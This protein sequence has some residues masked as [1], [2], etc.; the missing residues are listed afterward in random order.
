M[1]FQ[2]PGKGF[3]ERRAKFLAEAKKKVKAAVSSRDNLLIQTVCAVDEINKSSN[4]LFE[5]LCEWYGMHFP[6][7]K[8]SDNS[9][10]VEFV[11]G[12]DR[13]NPDMKELEK[14]FGQA[15]QQLYDKAKS[16][17]G[18]SFSEEDIRQVRALA[19]QVKML[20]TLRKNI[21]DYEI[22]LA[23]EICPNLSYLAG[24]TLAAKLVS[25]AGGLKRL[26]TMPSS[27]IQV[28]GAEKALFKHL[29]SGSRP[30]K[31]GLIFQHPLIS[32]SPKSVRGKISRLLAARLAIA[33][34]ADFLSHNF[35]AER[36]KASFEEA[37]KRL[38]ASAQAKKKS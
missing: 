20:W 19:L 33:A 38:I 37:A 10:Y 28:L 23:N 3:S 31:H 32:T 2:N 1:A 12:I 7:L 21:E 11:L 26:A 25:Q 5:R 17:M 27:T 9:K 18:A 22:K 8:L 14:M 34:K 16:S 13:Q 35:I 4:L 24:P 29:K 6:E 36:L 30:P 15:A